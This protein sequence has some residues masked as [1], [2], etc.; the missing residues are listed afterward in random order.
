VLNNSRKA[1]DGD[2]KQRLSSAAVLYTPVSSLAPDFHT[3]LL[4][5]ML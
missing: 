4:F 3:L 2:G 1:E 5:S